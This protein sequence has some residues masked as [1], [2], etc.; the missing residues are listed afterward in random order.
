MNTQ[1]RRRLAALDAASLADADK[2][3]R[4]MDSGLR[5][6]REGLKLVGIARTISCSEDFLTIIKAL[7]ESQPGEVLVVDTQHSQRAVVGELFSLEAE[8][9]GLAGIIVDGPVRDI[10]TVKTLSMSVYARSFYPCSGTTRQL[11]K[12]QLEIDCGGVVVRPGD[13][14]VGDDD[15]VIVGSE[16]EL[17][18][19]LDSA[20]MIQTSEAQI[21][22]RMACGESLLQ[23]LNYAEHVAAI[24]RGEASQLAFKL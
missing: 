20:E 14:I 10:S 9:R 24:E 6:L 2:S 5:P 1:L 13:I 21:R 3:L 11:G 12:T 23:M 15:G 22:E 8:R 16:T 7:D 4:V 19:V 18:A 17:S